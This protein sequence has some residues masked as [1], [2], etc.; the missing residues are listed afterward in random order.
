MDY[1]GFSKKL[2]PSLRCQIDG[3][4][5]DVAE[6]SAGND[7]LMLE[8]ALR[9]AAP[10]GH[11]YGI[12]NGI[13]D[14]MPHQPQMGEVQ[15]SEIQARDAQ[16]EQYDGLLASRY[17][18]E[19]PSTLAAC[20]DVASK[21]VMEYGCGTGRLT[22]EFLAADAILASD[23]SL[24]SLEVLSK[25]LAGK[26]NVG[27]VLADATRLVTAPDH[28]D[29]ALST[30]V[31]EHVPTREARGT[32]LE[33]IRETLKPGGICVTTAYHFDL[34]RRLRGRPK[35]GAHAS[36]IFY[37]YFSRAELVQEI[38]A[39]LLVTRARIIDISLPIEARL[40]LSP[41]IAGRLS[42]IVERLPVLRQ[43]GHLVLVAAAKGA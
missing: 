23:F 3:A 40:R 35:E 18:K 36:G 24:K 16:A 12:R 1:C 25:K 14:M 10:A 6:I 31:I 20:G 13:L 21:R 39:V 37:H 29:L 19:V 11:R 4:D 7:A 26:S 9:C 28:F 32:F 38:G 33:N 30:Q 22:V 15:A 2:I 42:R 5:L 17:A 34:R 8:G 43:F 27:L 41:S